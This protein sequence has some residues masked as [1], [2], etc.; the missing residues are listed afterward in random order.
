[1]DDN[2][3]II[4]NYEDWVDHCLMTNKILFDIGIQRE[5]QSDSPKFLLMWYLYND[6]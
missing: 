4:I 5:P 6:V 3:G 2:K 1:M